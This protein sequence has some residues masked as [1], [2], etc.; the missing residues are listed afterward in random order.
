MSIK[1]VMP[2]SHLILCCPLLLLPPVPPNIR[3]F[4]NESTL[5]MRGP[6]YWSFPGD[7]LDPGIKPVSPAWQVDSLP[8]SHLGSPESHSLPST[9]WIRGSTFVG[10][11]DHSTAVLYYMYLLKKFVCKWPLAVQTHFFPRV[12]C[13]LASWQRSWGFPNGLLLIAFFG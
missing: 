3:V 12:N 4:S 5:H 9:P 2:S 6:K 1:S 10:S 13:I 7:L 11:K 8:P